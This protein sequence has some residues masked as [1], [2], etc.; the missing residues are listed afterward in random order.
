MYGRGTTDDKGPVVGWLSAINSLQKA[1]NSTKLPVNIKFVFEGMEECG[2][3]GLD[4]FVLKEKNGFLKNID[5]IS[6]SDNYWLGKKTPCLTYGLRGISYF[7]VEIKGPGQDLHSGIYGG[8]VY[9]P[10]TDLIHLFGK[11]TDTNGNLMIPGIYDQVTPV[12]EEELETY[13]NL[14]YT[15]ETF[16]DSIHSSKKNDTSLHPDDVTKNLMSRWR[17]P[18]LS[19]HGI[20]GAFSA[21]GAKTVIPYRVIGKF[22]IRIVPKME[23]NDVNQMVLSYLEQQFK[24]LGTKNTMKATVI[25]SGNYFLSDIRH[26]NFQAASRALFRVFGKQPNLT[27]EGG[28]IPVAVTFQNILEKNVVLLPMGA[29]DDGPHSA[30]EKLDKTNFVDGIRAMGTY[31][32]ELHS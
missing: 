20:E 12:T 2:S 17:Y 8:S 23:Q 22:S 29:C 1:Y 32:H 28:S 10:M 5:Y 31:L 19:I 27:R 24:Q 21:S 3:E 18:C 13:S 9:E 26:P 7:C 25:H 16:L 15:M 30:K 11:L 14:D 6:I 4:D